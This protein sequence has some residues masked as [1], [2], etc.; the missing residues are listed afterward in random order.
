MYW[1]ITT[2]VTETNVPRRAK[3]IKHFIKI[4]S[5]TI[6]LH[7]TLLEIL[8]MYENYAMYMYII[9]RIVH[10]GILSLFSHIKFKHHLL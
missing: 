4:A 8:P 7:C 5:K 6:P 10:Y 1:V 2:V 9:M 3:L